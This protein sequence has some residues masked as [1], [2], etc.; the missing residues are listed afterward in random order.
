M[1]LQ[2]YLKGLLTASLAALLL[3]S[4]TPVFAATKI[5]PLGDSI[6]GSPGCW[7]AYLWEKLTLNNFTNIDMVGTLPAQGCAVAHDGDNEG[8][9]GILATNM[10]NQ[11][12]LPPWLSATKPD[13]VLMHLGTNDVWS[14]KPTTEILAAFT[15]LVQQMRASNTAV[16]IVVAKIIPMDS[17]RSCGSCADGVIALNNAL[18]AWAAG[19]STS[20]SP[21]TVADIWTGFSAIADTYDG[22][23][24]TD[25]G[26][27]KIADTWYPAVVTAL[28]GATS[29]SAASSST[30]SSS[31]K[32]SA[33]SSTSASSSSATA[34]ADSCNWYGH[35]TFPLCVTATSGFNFENGTTC[36]ARS[37]CLIQA[38]GYGGIIPGTCGQSS[39]SL[40]SSSSSISSSVIS[41][42]SRSSISSTSSISSKAS[43][44]SIIASSS[45]PSS[46]STPSSSSASSSSLASGSKCSYLVS[47]EWNTG[48]TGLIRITNK[49][50]TA[51]NGWTVNWSYS[52]GTKL[53]GS[54]N[55]TVTSTN[56]YSATNLSWNAIIQPGQSVELGV[57]GNKG[58]SPT[59]QIPVI[60]GSVC[61]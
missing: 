19:L 6:T 9:G 13:I 15:T 39:S 50:S 29:S 55:A 22:V 60:S 3:T 42:S 23:H 61:N 8:H 51:I 26:H 10:A 1:T 46:S 21:I 45:K 43:S 7:R 20:S 34:C 5:M 44:S 48:F 58:T 40:K 38:P 56:P 41:S 36:V 31:S 49:G 16:K 12:Q 32:S 14:S 2:K 33:V 4:V 30:L 28:G 53:T 11:S 25:A 59:A 47:N 27:K 37:T 24:P 57:Q 52:D 17:A 35:A 18:P 54:W